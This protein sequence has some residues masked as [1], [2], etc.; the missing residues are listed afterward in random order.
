VRA[1]AKG[2]IQEARGE[3]NGRQKGEE[4]N[5]VKARSADLWSGVAL[6]GLGAYI[7]SAASGWE[8]LGQDGPG[9]GFFPVW[10]G[11]A[12]VALSLALVVT[13]IRSTADDALDW[14]SAG[15]AFVLWAA[16]AVM[17]AAL[18]L[19]GFLAGFAALTFFVAA[20]MYR[21][22]LAVAAIVAVGLTAGFY[23]L[24]P[25]ALNVKLP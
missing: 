20:V 8:Y 1:R 15:H 7:I 9:P 25:L 22:P 21:K 11:I 24:F 23:V 6:G 4:E 10:Y 5:A 2:S 14:R 12:M 3:E 17:I 13:S 18:K 19:I 16:F